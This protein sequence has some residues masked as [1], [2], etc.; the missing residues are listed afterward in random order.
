[1]VESKEEIVTITENPND[2]DDD[3]EFY[4][5]LLIICQI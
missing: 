5:P 1:M 4:Y 2:I 3:L